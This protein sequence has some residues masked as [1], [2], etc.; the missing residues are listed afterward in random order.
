MKTKIS[1]VFIIA[2]LVNVSACTYIKNLFPDKEKDYQFTTE[3][4]PLVLPSDLMNN[5][6]AKVP[7]AAPVAETSVAADSID[8]AINVEPSA[9]QSETDQ[10][11]DRKLIQLE[12]VDADQ[13]TKRLRIGASSITAWRMVG[14]ALSRNSIEVPNRNQE[15]RLFHVQY[16]PNKQVVEDGSFWDELVFFF[17]GFETN[18]REYVLKLVENNQQTDVIIMD[19]Q[20]QP[21]ADQGSLR[22]LTLLHDAIKA[23]LAK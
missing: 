6:V 17:T 4:P 12:L 9:P 1:L 8:E 5:S 7:S 13:G 22:L 15:E 14:K 16:D 19:N 10:D 3:I 18:E 20:Q 23:D 11:I 2:V 21:V